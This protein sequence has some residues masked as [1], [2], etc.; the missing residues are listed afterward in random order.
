M[1]QTVSAKNL[2]PANEAVSPGKAVLPSYSTI[3]KHPE[4]SITRASP[5]RDGVQEAMSNEIKDTR[6]QVP[7]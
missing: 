6:Y 2:Y 5:G 7:T 1:G 4:G 3:I